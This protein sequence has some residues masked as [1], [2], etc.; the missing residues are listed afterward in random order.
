MERGKTALRDI[1]LACPGPG[2]R[3]IVVCCTVRMC[4]DLAAGACS[5]AEDGCLSLYDHP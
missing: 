2:E 4:R 5:A 3:I 1:L